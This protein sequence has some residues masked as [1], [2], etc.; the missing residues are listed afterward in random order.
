MRF[1]HV[2]RTLGATD[3][4]S[5]PGRGVRAQLERRMLEG[6]RVL[7]E[8]EILVRVRALSQPIREAVRTNGC[9]F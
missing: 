6:T 9:P 7:V 3:A 4:E 2:V 1:V 8:R 5:P